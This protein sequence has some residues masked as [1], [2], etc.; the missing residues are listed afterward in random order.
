MT[1]TIEHRPCRHCGEPVI[2]VTYPSGERRAV[3]FQQV[4]ICQLMEGRPPKVE[5]TH[6]GHPVHYCYQPK[7]QDDNAPW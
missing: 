7:E 3:N 5:E 4:V 1:E 6:V 2:E